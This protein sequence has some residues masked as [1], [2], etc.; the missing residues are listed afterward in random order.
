MTLAWLKLNVFTLLISSAYM[1]T[2]FF[3]NVAFLKVAPYVTQEKPQIHVF[4]LHSVPYAMDK[5]Y[6]VANLHRH[7]VLAAH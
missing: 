1:L 3:G 6:R 7:G 4:I 2:S 5:R